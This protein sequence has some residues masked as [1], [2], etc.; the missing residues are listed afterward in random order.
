MPYKD[1]AVRKKKHAAYSREHYLEN[2]DK[3]IKAN[4][5][6]KKKRRK[7]WSEYKATLACVQCGQNHPSTLDFHH[8]NPNEKEG[9]INRM[10]SNGQFKKAYAEIKKC[11]VLCANCHRI[12]HHNEKQKT[13]LNS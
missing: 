6:Y 1:L 2:K 12:H 10:I 5:E 8:E 9:D 4:S 3:Q 13:L 11:I 7:E